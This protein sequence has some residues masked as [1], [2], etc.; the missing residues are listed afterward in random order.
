MTPSSSACSSSA[1]S[2]KLGE[3]GFGIAIL[4]FDEVEQLHKVFKL[5]KDA[6]TTRALCK[7]GANLVKLSEL[8][9]PNII[10]LHQFG[11]V[12]LTWENADE[13][14]YY[15]NMAF[16]GSSLR[17]KLGR[18]RRELDENG[19]ERVFGGGRRLAPEEAARIAVDVCQGLE[20]AHGFRGA[21]IRMLHR[22]IKPAN[23]LIDDGTGIA[24]LADFGLSRV[25]A[26]SSSL[27]SGRGDVPVHGPGVLS[28]SSDRD[29]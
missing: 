16:G 12:H 9:H 15:I 10:R 5:P 11:K 23:I 13:D 19:N 26:R 1:P 29:F 22:D 25:I 24:R 20:A 2:E 27:V 21:R 8:L 18:L 6:N 17:A 4:V 7:E 14:R 3:G 28:W